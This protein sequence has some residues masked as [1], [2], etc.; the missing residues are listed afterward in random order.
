M[1]RRLARLA[2]KGYRAGKHVKRFGQ[3]VL[4]THDELNDA[5]L[6]LYDACRT[7]R[8]NDPLSPEERQAVLY[9]MDEAQS[10]LVTLQRGVQAARRRVE[11]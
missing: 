3:Q 2:K 6:L 11:A 5:S 4:D 1:L 10:V 7:M 8:Q 9:A